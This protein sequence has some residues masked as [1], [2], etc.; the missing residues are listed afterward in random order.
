MLFSCTGCVVPWSAWCRGV[1]D[2]V[3]C[4]VL[5]GAWCCGVP[6][7]VGCLVPWGAWYREVP[8]AVGCL[9]PSAVGCVWSDSILGTYFLVLRIDAK[10]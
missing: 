9:V 2:A 3:G 4:L 8:G 1:P 7:A 10:C 6:G 5:W